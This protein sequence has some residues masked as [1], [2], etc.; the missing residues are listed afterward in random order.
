MWSTIQFILPC[1]RKDLLC[2]TEGFVF[3]QLLLVEFEAL[4]NWVQKAHRALSNYQG[5]LR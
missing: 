1:S 3:S 4:S 5:V 2:D